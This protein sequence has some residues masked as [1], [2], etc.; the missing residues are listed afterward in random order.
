[1]PYKDLLTIGRRDSPQFKG[2]NMKCVICS[3]RITTDPDGWAG[4][5]NAEPILTGRCCRYCNEI[6][7]IRRLND[8]QLLRYQNRKE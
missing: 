1:M 5:H 6:V 4:G 7:I 8:F 2:E 3:R